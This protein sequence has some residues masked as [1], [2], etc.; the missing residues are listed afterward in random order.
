M[1]TR[2]GTLCQRYH[3]PYDSPQQLIFQLFASINMLTEYLLYSTFGW[4]RV[5]PAFFGDSKKYVQEKSMV[6]IC[7]KD[8]N[9]ENFL[10][11]LPH[12]LIFVGSNPS[13]PFKTKS[14]PFKTYMVTY[15]YIHIY[16]FFIFQPIVLDVSPMFHCSFS[17]IPWRC[18]GTAASA[19]WAKPWRSACAWPFWPPCSARWGTAGTAGEWKLQYGYGSI[20]INTIFNTIFRGMNI[21]KS[22]LFW[23]ELQGYQG[24]DTLPYM[25]KGFHSHGDTRNKRIYCNDFMVI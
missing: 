5:Q 7:L 24:F 23:C 8:K 17:F 21:H 3:V 1:F 4:G 16:I 2:P 25:N 20:P 10:R 14:K 15:I 6:W 19:S 22:Q 13:S 9:P 11:K 18:Q 12:Q